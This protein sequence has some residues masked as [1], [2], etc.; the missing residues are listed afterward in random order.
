MIGW[1]IGVN[2]VILDDTT[3]TLGN[4]VILDTMRSGKKKSRLISTSAPETFPVSM[5]FTREEWDVFKAWYKTNL[6]MGALT[7]QFPKIAGTGMGEYRILPSPSWSQ[8]TARLVKVNMIW[9]E[10]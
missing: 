3:G 9:E 8:L 1:P 5:K 7:F 4:G 6:R 10:A 2:Q